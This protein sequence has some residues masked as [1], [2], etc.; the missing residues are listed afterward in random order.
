M[1]RK[2]H[3]DACCTVKNGMYFEESAQGYDIF[4]IIDYFKNKKMEQDDLKDA[5]LEYNSALWEVSKL[6]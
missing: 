5:K 3:G 1:L 2:F 4:P 6:I